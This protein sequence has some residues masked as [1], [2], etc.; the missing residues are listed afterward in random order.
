MQFFV[1]SLFGIWVDH[2]PAWRAQPWEDQTSPEAAG[3]NIW[4]GKR[5]D[6]ETPAWVGLSL[7]ISLSELPA[8]ISAVPR[9]GRQR[10][11]ATARRKGQGFKPQ[12]RYYTWGNN[13]IA[14]A[15]IKGNFSVC[16]QSVSHCPPSAVQICQFWESDTSRGDGLSGPVKWS[17][18]DPR[19][20]M[21][22]NT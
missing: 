16:Q 4:E 3:P 6:K 13:Y 12:D 2:G 5:S 21:T 15:G 17:A 7:L 8:H 9:D 22:Q 19:H 20:R 14:A 1:C 18:A 10:N 11:H